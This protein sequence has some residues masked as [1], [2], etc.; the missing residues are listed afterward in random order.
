MKNNLS[1]LTLS[2]LMFT[3]N[4]CD[5][6]GEDDNNNNDDTGFDT[7]IVGESGI[8]ENLNTTN[9]DTSGFPW[10]YQDDVNETGCGLSELTN[11]KLKRWDVENEGLIPVKIG[12]VPFATEALDAIEDKLGMTLF[13]RTS[14]GNTP[15]ENVSKGLIFSDGTASGPNPSTDCGH[16]SSGVGTFSYPY[17]GEDSE[18]SSENIYF[19]YDN[20]GNIVGHDNPMVGLAYDEAGNAVGNILEDTPFIFDDNGAVIGMKADEDEL[21]KDINGNAI[22]TILYNK[23]LY[24]SDGM[25]IGANAWI[26]GSHED[27]DA[28][29]IKYRA[30]E[31]PFYDATGR[32]N[33][34]L[35]VHIGSSACESEIDL[36][37]VVHEIGHALGLGAHFEGFGYGPAV[38]GNFWNVLNTLYHNPIGSYGSS[39]DIHQ[40]EF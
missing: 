11:G 38:D 33:T 35:Y 27:R 16:V 9:L 24:D 18:Y 25:A 2:L 28:Y 14:I 12:T 19:E 21:I 5:G 31:D 3:L 10:Y 29:L 22:C 30:V 37:L 6:S 40:I 39:V 34:V 8:L 1:I 23:T 32:I 15:N 20:E 7:E 26:S 13:D 4:S 36:D 17:E